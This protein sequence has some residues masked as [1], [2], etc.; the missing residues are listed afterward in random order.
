MNSE[1][2]FLPLLTVRWITV[3]FTFYTVLTPPEISLVASRED[4]VVNPLASHAR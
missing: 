2:R 3:A 1:G 4:P